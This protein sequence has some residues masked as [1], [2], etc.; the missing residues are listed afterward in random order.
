MTKKN[1]YKIIVSILLGILTFIATFISTKIDFN[2]FSINFIWSLILPL[3]VTLSWGMKYGMLSITI[4][5]VPLYP[6]FLG[7]YNGWASFVPALSLYLWI[8]IHGFGRNK[9]IYNNEFYYN[10]YFLQFVYIILRMI[11]YLV[12]FPIL[13]SFNP[14]FWNPDA[15]T[16]IEISIVLLFAI[17]G[18]IVESIFL[19]LA[20]ALLYLGFIRKIF[21]LKYSK[22]ARYNTRIMISIISFGL[23]FTLLISSVNNYI[24]D[25]NNTLNWL[26]YPD[27]KTKITFLLSF[28]LFIIMGGILIRFI[29]KIEKLNDELEIRVEK[30]TKELKESLQE[31]E[32]FS[33]TIS[34]DIKSPLRAIDSYSEFL[35]E[36]YDEILPKDAKDM[37][38]NIRKTSNDIILLTDKLLE[39]STTNKK[40]L[41]KN[42]IKIEEMIKDITNKLKITIPNKDID[43]I[44]KSKLPI[45]KGDKILLEQVILNIISNSIKFS[46]MREKIII[47]V[48]YMDRENKYIF[49][50]K[51]NGVG[52][53][54]E[55]SHKLF[56]LFKR[57][58]RK[59]EF[60]GTGIGLATIKKIIEKHGGRVWIEGKVNE[61]TIIYFT[62]PK[63]K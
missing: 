37:V 35:I 23:I 5:L 13:I 41:E 34:H 53:D 14:P 47:E 43:L 25:Q 27:E 12:L 11:I 59:T 28:L 57:L 58:H 1:I 60:E 16:Q 6:F 42:D 33:Y 7:Y 56:S 30:R 55:Y 21:K 2:G 24:I 9:R 22:A 36:D 8:I 51:D 32:G 52:F 19:A 15:Y 54:M 62:I 29:E 26:I 3:L 45:I 10:M 49:S 20:D 4:G 48:D 38:F 31:L 63:G 44:F 46:K 17:K 61:G 50:I 18:I 40:Q 39:Y